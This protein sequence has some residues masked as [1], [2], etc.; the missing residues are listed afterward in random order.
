MSI[1]TA[2][3][4]QAVR[5]PRYDPSMTAKERENYNLQQRLYRLSRKSS[6]KPKDYLDDHTAAQIEVVLGGVEI[7]KTSPR[8]FVKWTPDAGSRK[9]LDEI[10]EALN[11]Y[12]EHLPLTARQ[13][14]YVLLDKYHHEKGTTFE[15]ALYYVM[16]RGRRG[17]QIDMDVIRDDSGTKEETI[18][19][20][21]AEE[22]LSNKRYQAAHA[23]LDR[24][25]GQKR[26]CIVYC[27]AV[28]MVPQLFRVTDP[29]GIPVH[30]SGGF[31]SIPEKHSLAKE[32]TD[33][34]VFHIGDLDAHGDRDF[35]ALAEDVSAFA[36]EFGNHV[37]FT[38]LAVT[39]E[40]ITQLGLPTSPYV[41]T[42]NKK[43][44][45]TS[46]AYPHDYTCQ[47]EA[48]RPDELARLVREAI[49]DP[50]R[51]NEKAYNKVLRR[52]KALHTELAKKLRS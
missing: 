52:E 38:R 20:A 21:D 13:V 34:D 11:L 5:R 30:S 29:Y 22:W 7:G 17:G 46:P 24:Q 9:L 33:T 14:Y 44:V 18:F 12:R 25:E 6:F 45:I 31:D 2:L 40:L 41:P 23:R 32:N 35:V 39:P 26:R 10:H 27:E 43:G 36:A 8:G 16:E 3:P 4:A 19:W 15:T 50:A 51:F 48:I 1:P 49:T 28:G 47:A 37:S 42:R